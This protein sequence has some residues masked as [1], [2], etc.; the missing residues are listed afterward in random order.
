MLGRVATYLH[1]VA[2]AELEKRSQVN[3]SVS[4]ADRL[5]RRGPRPGARGRVTRQVLGNLEKIITGLESDGPGQSE[6]T[7]GAS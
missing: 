7:A 5:G 3:L 6:A 4:V 2:A 1:N